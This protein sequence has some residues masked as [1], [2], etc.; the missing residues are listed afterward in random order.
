MGHGLRSTATD[1]EHRSAVNARAALLAA[2]APW[3]RKRAIATSPS[4]QASEDRAAEAYVRSL[5]AM[6]SYDLTSGVPLGAFLIAKRAT[7]GERVALA[8]MPLDQLTQKQR[9]TAAH[10]CHTISRPASLSTPIGEGDGRTLDDLVPSH[11]EGPEELAERSE[12]RAAIAEALA[13]L[14]TRQRTLVI[15]RFG[16]DGGTPKGLKEIAGSRGTTIPNM[17]KAVGHVLT[18]IRNGNPLLRAHLTGN[19]VTVG[20]AIIGMAKP[21]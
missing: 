1:D 9:R 6:G 7:A 17:S 15:D 8:G 5:E 2:Y 19:N 20:V 12:L 18:K 4:R 14:T 10:T 3:I 16:L 11:A 13:D 21:S